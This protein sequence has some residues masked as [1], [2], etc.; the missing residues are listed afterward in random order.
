MKLVLNQQQIAQKINRLAHELVENSYG[1]T[2]LFIGGII[3]NGEIFA[4]Q[5]ASIVRENSKQKITEFTI[6]LHKEKPLEHPI[7]CSVDQGLF[8]GKM[9]VVVDDVINSGTTMQY[10]VIKV[11][12]QSVRSVKT[13]ALVDRMHRRYPIKCD[14]VG[15]T[16]STTLGERVE[17]LPSN[18]SL[19][20]FLV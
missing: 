12:E 5:I 2:E 13:L 4:K 10:A 9:V 14:F 7:N 3:G 8:K 19:E 6:D 16:L 17:V 15:V 18:N 11:L 20:A 1:E